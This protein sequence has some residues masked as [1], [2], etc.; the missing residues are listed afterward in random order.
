ML[1]IPDSGT[2]FPVSSLL[3]KLR[4]RFLP[5]WNWD[6]GIR[7]LEGLRILW[8]HFLI[9]GSGFWI[10][11]A[12]ISQI[13]EFGL[14]YMGHRL[15][16][17]SVAFFIRL[18]RYQLYYHRYIFIYFSIII[19][20]ICHKR[21]DHLYSKHTSLGVL[22]YTVLPSCV[23]HMHCKKYCFSR[24]LALI[25]L[26]LLREMFLWQTHGVRVLIA[27]TRAIC[28]LGLSRSVFVVAPG[29]SGHS[30]F[31][32]F[33]FSFIS[34][35]G[36]KKYRHSIH[37]NVFLGLKNEPTFLNSSSIR[38]MADEIF[39]DFDPRSVCNEDFIAIERG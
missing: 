8:A 13:P 28:A 32:P 15:Y 9:F 1:V 24:Q 25:Q 17:H 2:G 6:S 3:V 30:S 22:V 33:S 18:F 34:F 21:R 31:P 23:F 12:K 10:P 39:T 16:F 14:S 29:G 11:Q 26:Q 20:K 38:N 4:L 35:V 5:Y 37:R 36:Q 7:S 19:C 27:K